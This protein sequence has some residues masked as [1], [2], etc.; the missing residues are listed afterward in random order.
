MLHSTLGS[1]PI[2]QV[3]FHINEQIIAGGPARVHSPGAGAR[4]SPL[5]S[6]RD[7]LAAAAEVGE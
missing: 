6:D 7:H 4:R 2:K 5:A 1:Q 3:L